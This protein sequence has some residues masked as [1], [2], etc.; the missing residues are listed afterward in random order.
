[1]SPNCALNILN[2]LY[3][4]RKYRIFHI[5]NQIGFKIFSNIKLLINGGK[6]ISITVVYIFEICLSL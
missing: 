6:N 2:D 4:Q 1:M 3:T 5:E